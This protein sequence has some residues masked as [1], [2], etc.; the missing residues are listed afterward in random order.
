MIVRRAIILV[1]VAAVVSLFSG[2]GTSNSQA[3]TLDAINK[4]PADW[5]VKHRNAYRVNPGQCRECHGEN[6]TGGITRVDCFNQG[7]STQCHAG[8]HGPRSI[9][10]TV[11]FSDPLSHGPMARADLM[12]CQDCHGEPGGPGSNPRF[13]RLIGSL[14]TGCE[15][16]P[17]CHDPYMAHP[18]PW[19]THGSAGNLANACLLCHGATFGGGSGPA[20]ITCHTALAAGN[21]PVAGACISCH[22][23]PPA[24]NNHVKHNGIAGITGSCGVCHNGAGSGS[25]LH[26]NGTADVGFL[27]AYNAKTGTASLGADKTCSNI[28]CH[29]GVTTPAWGGSISVA[30][31]CEAC[32]VAGTAAQSPQFNSYYSGQ[33]SRHINQVGLKCVDCHDMT[34][35][36]SGAS[37]FST[38]ATPS[39]ELLPARTI[40]VPG[41]ATTPGSCNPGR[42]P[43]ANAYSVGVCHGTETWQ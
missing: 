40:K 3:P 12:I 13:S 2:C 36:N 34:V 15:K 4:H 19:R 27:A 5:L 39:F 10:H 6:L 31:H 41:Y 9:I 22:G 35:V 43:Q 18:K 20:C 7:A 21:I 37:H 25:S 32:H 38:L 8:G 17:G 28:S 14:A 33:H 29:G 24:T 1:S 16:T 26:N 30:D 23:K 11:P 42:T